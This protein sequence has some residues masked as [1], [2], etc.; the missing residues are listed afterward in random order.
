MAGIDNNTVLYLRGDSFNDLS[1]NPKNIVSGET[2][3]SNNAYYIN[4]NKLPIK[5]A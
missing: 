1:L 2:V 3:I 5:V 4:S